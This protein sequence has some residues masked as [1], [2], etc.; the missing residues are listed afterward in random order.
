MH[1]LRKVRLVTASLNDAL[2]VLMPVL[3][4][5]STPKR[6]LVQQSSLR[7]PLRLSDF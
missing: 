3:G 2:E 5:M 6:E 4:G 1:E 7:W